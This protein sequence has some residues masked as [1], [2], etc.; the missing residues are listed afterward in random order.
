MRKVDLVK[1]KAAEVQSL[2]VRCPNEEPM[3]EGETLWTMASSCSVQ[4]LMDDCNI[5][6][7]LQELVCERLRCPKCD[8][9]FDLWSK[10]G[11]K[12]D[13]NLLNHTYTVLNPDF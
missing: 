1:K 8:T 4:D 6:E 9:T 12:Y 10:M 2:I 7:N 3:V 5:P 13:L 11:T